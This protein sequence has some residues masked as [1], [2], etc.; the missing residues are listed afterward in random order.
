MANQVIGGDYP[1]GTP[2]GVGSKGPSVAYT[3][4]RIKSVELVTSQN[5]KKFVGAAGWGLVGMAVLG[6]VGGLAGVLASG[7][8]T[9]ICFACQLHNGRRFLATADSKVYEA[10]LAAS[11]SSGPSGFHNSELKRRKNPPPKAGDKPF[12][13]AWMTGKHP[14]PH[15]ADQLQCA[16]CHKWVKRPD[17]LC[18]CGERM[19]WEEADRLHDAVIE[20]A[21]RKQ[22]R[23]VPLSSPANPDP[24]TDPN[25]PQPG[26]KKC[27]HCDE[28]INAE[29]LKC[30]YCREWLSSI[31]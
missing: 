13:P 29:A 24:A 23:T 25:A 21:T 7:N 9:Q 12:L 26:M 20:A 28:E 19:P 22:Y 5:Q 30:R 1:Q 8:R 3:Y 17:E 31:T 6:P 16:H 11:M 27:P 15:K 10:F 14:I 18:S 4:P 2:I